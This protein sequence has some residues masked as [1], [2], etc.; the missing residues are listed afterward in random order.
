MK[1][2]VPG[3]GLPVV[4]FLF[5]AFACSGCATGGIE[6]PGYT[7]ERKDGDFEVRAYAEQVVAETRVKGTL[8]FG[9]LEVFLNDAILAESTAFPGTDVRAHARLF[10]R[11]LLEARRET[12][13]ALNAIVLFLTTGSVAPARRA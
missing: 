1:C 7:V 4:V 9:P 2:E 10:T 8:G 11:E 12:V 5:L 3:D 13:Q 6:K